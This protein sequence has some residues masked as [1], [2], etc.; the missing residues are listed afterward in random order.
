MIPLKIGITG[1]IGVGKTTVAR[2]FNTLGIPCYNSDES[3]KQLTNTDRN[4]RG[5]IIQ[6]L[7]EKAYNSEGKYD[8]KLVSKIVFENQNLLLKLNQLIHPAVAHDFECW[9]SQQTTPY[10][11]KEAAI[12]FE[13]KAYLKLDYTI[14]VTAPLATRIS[15]IKARDNKNEADILNV[16]NAQMPEEEKIKLANFVI[17]NDEKTLLIPQLIALHDQILAKISNSSSAD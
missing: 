14:L 10:I 4:L 13:S 17:N 7:G 6:L 9:L 2:F 3:A 8:R 1:G 11:L 12:L 16:I 15:R 5:Q